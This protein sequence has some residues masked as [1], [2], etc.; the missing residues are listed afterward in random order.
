MYIYIIIYIYICI[1]IIIYILCISYISY[2][3]YIYYV[4]IYV[5]IIYIYI[6]NVLLFYIGASQDYITKEER[7][8]SFFLS[9]TAT[10]SENIQKFICNFA[11]EMATSYF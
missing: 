6:Y 10:G 5:Y 11:C 7:E 3:I 4:I 8:P 1:Y 2:N 9:T